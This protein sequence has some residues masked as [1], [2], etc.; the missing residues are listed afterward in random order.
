MEN[1]FFDNLQGRIVLVGLGNPLLGDDGAGPALIAEINKRIK[2]SENHINVPFFRLKG[3]LFIDA[4]ETPE[5]YLGK[6]VADNPDTVLLVDAADFKSVPG[7]LK[8]IDLKDIRGDGLS[9]HNSSVKL[10]ADYIMNETGAKVLFLGIQKKSIIM[11]EDLSKPVKKAIRRIA[12][13]IMNLEN[14]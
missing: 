2:P 13:A 5:N 4:G 9:T 14:H 3:C 8:M 1:D 11:G 6:I 7:A 10:I 12:D